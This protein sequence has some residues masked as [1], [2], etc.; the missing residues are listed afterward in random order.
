MLGGLPLDSYVNDVPNRF[1]QPS[2]PTINT[3]RVR[4]GLREGGVY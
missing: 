4:G 1:G 2:G 3:S